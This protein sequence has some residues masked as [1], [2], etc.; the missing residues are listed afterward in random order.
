MTKKVNHDYKCEW[1]EKKAVYNLQSQWHLYDIDNDGEMTE[2]DYWA[3]E[4]NE[5]WCEKCYE[6]HGQTS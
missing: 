3:G 5:F 2:N 4:T 6:K 1:C